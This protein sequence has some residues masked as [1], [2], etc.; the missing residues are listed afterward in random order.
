M[1]RAQYSC[2]GD[3]YDGEMPEIVEII[4]LSPAPTPFRPRNKNMHRNAST[5]VKIEKLTALEKEALAA[6]QDF[7]CSDA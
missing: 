2:G 6:L 3:E 1:L 5:A 4:L 7:E